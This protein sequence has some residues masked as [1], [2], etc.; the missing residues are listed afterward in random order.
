MKYLLIILSLSFLA[1][2]STQTIKL[3]SA[4][5][6][7]VEK[8]NHHFFFQG[9]GQKRDINTTSICKDGDKVVQVQSKMNGMQ[10]FLTTITLA[11]YTPMTAS[12]YCAE[13]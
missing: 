9:I 11:I 1:S 12:V 7:Y 2:C 5:Y 4:N 3:D 10:V 8:Q 6:D 13:K